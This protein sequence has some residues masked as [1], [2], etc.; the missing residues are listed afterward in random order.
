ADCSLEGVSNSNLA[1]I[2][3]GRISNWS[4]VAGTEG[5][6]CDAPISRVVRKD[7]SGTT[8]Q[9]KNYLYQLNK[10]GLSCTVG[11]TEGKQSWQ[12]L[13]PIGSTDA[14]N[15][16]WPESCGE[17]SLSGIVQPAGA[18]GAEEVKAVN[19]TSGSIGYASL[20][21]AKANLAGGTAILGLQNN[22]QKA[23]VNLAKPAG[24]EETANCGGIAYSGFK[25]G[26]GRDVDWSGVYG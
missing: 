8:Y 16:S 5:E 21:E 10:K 20:P 22:G 4:K 13:E 25:L 9:L 1:G 18:G 2:F 26:T 15:T 14:P 11:G 7:G 19:A 24:N 17:K 6:G 3:E 12:E 23:D